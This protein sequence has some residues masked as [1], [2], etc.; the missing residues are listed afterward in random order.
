MTWKALV[1]VVAVTAVPGCSGGSSSPGAQPGACEKRCGACAA[2]LKQ[3]MRALVDEGY[4]LDHAWW[5]SA[6]LATLPPGQASDPLDAGAVITLSREHLQYDGLMVASTPAVEADPGE[7]VVDLHGL[8]VAARDRACADAP[9]ADHGSLLLLI[10]PAV[11]WRVVRRVVATA[12]AAGIDG[13]VF[14]FRKPTQVTP[15]GRSKIDAEIERIER[16][17]A[18]PRSAADK[19]AQGLARDDDPRHPL[20]LAYGPCK[21]ARDG[22][23]AASGRSAAAQR[24]FLVEELPAALE[25][26]GCRAEPASIQALHWWWSGRREGGIPVGIRLTLA[27]GP[28]RVAIRADDDASWSQVHAR[29]A[30]AAGQARGGFY[31]A[32]ARPTETAPPVRKAGAA[33]AP[34]AP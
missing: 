11:S 27:G 25:A 8:L 17:L 23:L 13:L 4:A 9:D 1:A 15:P 5:T 2:E 24:D 12:D 7:L 26:C 16:E 21:P 31:L 22:L 14:G 32:G 6:A 20:T 19:L 3:W 10:D 28:D 18:A 30:A 29:V 33:C 34:A